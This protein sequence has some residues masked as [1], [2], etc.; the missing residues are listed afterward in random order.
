M[1]YKKQ[2][3]NII[4]KIKNKIFF[5]ISSTIIILL[6]LFLIDFFLKKKFN[7][8]NPILYYHH[9]NFGYAIRPD[10]KIIR[11][12]KEIKIDQFGSR[13]NFIRGEGNKFVFYGDSVLYGGRLVNN[14]ELISELTCKYL[15]ANNRC[16][17]FGT[18]AYGL[19]NITKR[20]KQDQT[21]YKNDFAIFVFNYDNL[22]RGVAK[23]SGQPFFNK[24]IDGNFK[25]INEVILRYVDIKR[26]KYR[27]TQSNKL[28]FEKYDKYLLDSDKQI[29]IEVQN[30]YQEIIDDLLYLAKNKFNNYLIVINYSKENIDENKN[31][32]NLKKMMNN[33]DKN[34][35]IFLSD[36]FNKEKIEFPKIFF[37]NVHL[38]KFG[39]NVMAKIIA[40]HI[41]NNYE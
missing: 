23:L 38:N 29:K 12:D 24:P 41:K 22:K 21:N 28:E 5:L 7:L 15:G 9:P 33:Y 1:S 16:L 40:K 4:S 37:D 10:Q 14:D 8:G 18:N 27:Y 25:A 2:L 39:H 35:I 20:V 13:S 19:E 3:M 32:I 6:C 30:Y 34:K 31:N 11:F 17:N 26:L 36:Y